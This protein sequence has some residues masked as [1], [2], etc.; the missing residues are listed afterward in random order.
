MLLDDQPNLE[1]IIRYYP[2][3]KSTDTNGKE[4]IEYANRYQIM[5]GEVDKDSKR[6]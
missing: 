5:L 6:K 1:Q 4:K 2:E 3:L